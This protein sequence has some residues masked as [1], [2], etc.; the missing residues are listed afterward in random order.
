MFTYVAV[1]EHCACVSLAVSRL[2]Q[3]GEEQE[4]VSH[5]NAKG[6]KPIFHSRVL[7]QFELRRQSQLL[8]L[9]LLIEERQYSCLHPLP[10]Q[11]AVITVR[12]DFELV[13][14]VQFGKGC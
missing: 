6:P 12:V 14:D 4:H 3:A 5:I 10:Y 8:K 2:S 13:R 7:R 9:K 1:H 11:A